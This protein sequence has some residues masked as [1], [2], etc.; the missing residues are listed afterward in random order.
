[1]ATKQ[2]KSRKFPSIYRTITDKKNAPLVVVSMLIITGILIVGVDLNSNLNEKNLRQKVH[3]SKIEEIKFWEENLP[4]YPEYRDAYFR[5]A[6]LYYEVGNFDKSEEY[7]KKVFF[8]D[9][10]FEEGKKLEKLLKD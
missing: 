3:T 6:V 10:S 9:P 4:K 1:M 5:I 8:L 2:N 7:L